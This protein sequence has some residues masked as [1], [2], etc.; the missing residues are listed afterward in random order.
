MA[1]SLYVHIP[2]CKRKCIY[3]NFYSCIYKEGDASDYVDAI[4][5]QLGRL[6]EPFRTVYVG[7]G[8]PTALSLPLLKKLMQG[9]SHLSKDSAE[10]TFEANPESLD[11]EKLKI[12]LGHGV[13]RLS[14]GM[15]SLKDE[16]LKALGR[17]HDARKAVEAV[18][19]ASKSGFDNISI[20]LIFGL[21][22]ERPD[23]WKR[24]LE[25]AV[26]LPV[27]HISC[28]ELTYEKGTPL[29]GM[30]ENKAITPPEDDAVAGMYEIAI[31]ELALRGFKQYEVSNFAKPGFE[32][33]HNTNYWEN[34]P[35]LGLGA[36]AFSYDGAT[37]SKN[38]SDACEYAR[39]VLTGKNITD[40][41]EKLPPERRAKETAA[42]KIRTRDGID[43][44]WFKDKTGYDLENLAKKAIPKLIDEGFIKYKRD[45]D[46]IT[47]ICLKRK[48][49]LFCDTVSSSLL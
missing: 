20:D 37:R 33:R 16:K 2:F 46:T 15:Q 29:F 18:V 14:I 31:E 4:L 24:E 36:A 13:N 25:E 11:R 47:G 5:L 49:F 6:A 12:L 9:L 23:Q 28:Y 21:W 42:V 44:S 43:F 3:C 45:K 38:I 35:Y 7:G 40:F 17:I 19:S 41:S 22:G 10:F 32:S 39:L 30:L 26:R 34:S 27:K 8:T 1:N 48:G